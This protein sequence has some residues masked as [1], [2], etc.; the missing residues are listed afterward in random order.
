MFHS[1]FNSAAHGSLS[2][3]DNMLMSSAVK[4]KA[5]NLIT[6]IPDIVGTKVYNDFCQQFSVNS[7]ENVGY[8]F[9]ILDKEWYRPGQIVEGRVFLELFIPSF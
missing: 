8:M 7:S 1:P 3:V 4:D 5:R 2:L 6:Q 9:L